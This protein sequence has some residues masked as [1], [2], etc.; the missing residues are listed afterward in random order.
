MWSFDSVSECCIGLI[1]KA[2]LNESFSFLFVL[3]VWTAIIWLCNHLPHRR[4][5]IDTV[6]DE[7]L[8]TAPCH[9]DAVRSCFIFT[10][11]RPARSARAEL[12]LFYYKIGVWFDSF[13]CIL[14]PL[15]T[16]YHI[17]PLGSEGFFG[18]WVLTCPHICAWLTCNILMAQTLL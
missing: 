10:P 5:A 12:C 4:P 6:I 11:H 17:I 9:Q 15:L 8:D 2:N 18:S 1:I 7:S 16:E 3:I 13:M 14:L